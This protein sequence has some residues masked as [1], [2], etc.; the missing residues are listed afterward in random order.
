MK[1]MVKAGEAPDPFD[2]YD[3][4][5]VV[6]RNDSPEENASLILE[7]K[8]RLNFVDAT[9]ANNRV[10]R[11]SGGDA[12]ARDYDGW[13]FPIV[14]WTQAERQKFSALFKKRAEQFWNERFVLF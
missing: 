7:L 14:H 12:Y 11:S 13:F 9:N 2:R 1:Y 4:S 10:I 6:P 8:V 5:L 3:S